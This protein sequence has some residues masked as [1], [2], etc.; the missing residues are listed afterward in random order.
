MQPENCA[1]IHAS[2]IAGVDDPVATEPL[3]TI[4]EGT[5]IARPVRLK[6][7]L[8][9]IRR[10]GGTTVTVTEE[11]IVAALRELALRHGLH[12]EP[13]SAAAAAGLTKLVAA[14]TIR[15]SETTV[16]VLTGSG[17]KATQRIGELLDRTG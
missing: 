7:V 1:P 8:E 11:E 17:L 6:E 3:P 5:A 15:A 12:A 4:A 9:A 14:G 2:F 10:S 13:T 16:V